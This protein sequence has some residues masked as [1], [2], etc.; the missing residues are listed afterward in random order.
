MKNEDKLIYYGILFYYI[1]IQMYM[2][3]SEVSLLLVLVFRWSIHLIPLFLLFFIAILSILFYRIKN[4]PIINIWIILLVL[5]LLSA[6]S[7][8]GLP[9]RHYLLDGDD[10]LYSLYN[11][12]EIRSAIS[13]YTSICKEVNIFAFLGVSYLKYVK[14]KKTDML[15]PYVGDVE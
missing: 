5:F 10:T 11:S 8:F 13:D 2:T 9:Y 7:A 1:Y 12:A 14:M 4:I 3:F 15:H 6:V